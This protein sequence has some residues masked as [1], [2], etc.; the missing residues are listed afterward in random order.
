[1]LKQLGSY[2]GQYKKYAILTPIFVILEVVCELIMPR[3]M[4]AIVDVGIPGGDL[5]YIIRMGALMLA[6]AAISMAVGV[7]SA[8]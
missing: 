5:G 8:R 6:L 3:V 7:L 2:I 4:A 1:M